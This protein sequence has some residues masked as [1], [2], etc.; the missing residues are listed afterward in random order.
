MNEAVL[1]ITIADHQLGCCPNPTCQH[2]IEE[3]LRI[4]QCPHENCRQLFCTKCFTANPA[5]DGHDCM[6]PHCNQ[7]LL[8]PINQPSQ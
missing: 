5:G 4:W 2:V 6:C 7:M 1:R 3:N 8:F